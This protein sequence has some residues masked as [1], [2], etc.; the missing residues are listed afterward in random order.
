VH[1]WL[2]SGV[3]PTAL[4]CLNDRVAMGTYQALAVN[5]LDVPRDV[6]VLSFDGS[7]LAGWLRP[8]VTSVA[9]PFA[10]LGERAVRLLLEPQ[11]PPGEVVR[12]PMGVA[13]GRSL[14][15]GR[16]A[17]RRHRASAG[18]G[19]DGGLLAGLA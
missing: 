16:P 9:L 18:G 6:A 2:M 12:V 4:V 19:T 5:G 13:E 17:V 10:E 1:L 7:E 14:P 11:G 8:P 3:K 15:V